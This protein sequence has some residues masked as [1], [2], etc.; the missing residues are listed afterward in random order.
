MKLKF[1]NQEFENDLIVAN[2]LMNVIPKFNV[3]P[4]PAGEV[5]FDMCEISIEKSQ[6]Q[7][8]GPRVDVRALNPDG[9]E[10]ETAYVEGCDEH[11][12]YTYQLNLSVGGQIATE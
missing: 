12:T 6:I 10:T 11:T 4:H 8:C 9:S 7:F 2:Y 3:G 5:M 1:R